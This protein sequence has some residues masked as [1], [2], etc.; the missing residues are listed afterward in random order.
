MRREP[1]VA[2]LLPKPLQ[3]LVIALLL[4]FIGLPVLYVCFASV[5]SDLAVAE[6]AFLPVELHV[7]NYA[8]IWSTVDLGGGLANSLLVAG[9]V[10]VACA[11]VSVGSANVR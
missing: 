8:R 11:G 10:A 2:R 9:A 1:A 6:G 3:A 5:N 7:D 4:S